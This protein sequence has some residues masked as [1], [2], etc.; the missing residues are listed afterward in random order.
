M[1]FWC[2]LMRKTAFCCGLVVAVDFV[3]RLFFCKNEESFMVSFVIFGLFR[4]CLENFPARRVL[5]FPG[6]LL[7]K[8]M[9]KLNYFHS[10]F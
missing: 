1:R 6:M 9:V 8:N 10:V 7:F 3:S 5:L 4:F 2:V